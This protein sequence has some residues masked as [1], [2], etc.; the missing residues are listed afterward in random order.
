MSVDRL[1]KVKSLMEEA[2]LECLFVTPGP[3]QRYLTGLHYDYPG[4]AWDT[5]IT[6]DLITVEVVPLDGDPVVVAPRISAD[7]V[8]QTVDVDDV[9]S[10][11]SAENRTA[12]LKDLL[13]RQKGALGMEDHVPFKIFE[14][15]STAIPRLKMRNA[16]GL[17]S[18]ARSVKSSEE[19]EFM[20]QAAKIVEHGV[21]VGRE[22]IRES[23]TE[24]E[25]SLEVERAMRERGAESI[26][27]CVVQTGAKTASWD[28][29][30]DDRVKKGDMFLMDLSATYNGYHADV[31]RPT[32]VG[33][34][35]EK[36]KKVHAIILEAQ[37]RAIDTVQAGVKAGKV[38]EAASRVISESGYGDF[39]PFGI[40]HGLGLEAHEIPHLTEYRDMEM[41]LLPGM[42]MTLEPTIN[43][44]GEFGLRIEDDILVTDGGRE[45]LT[46]IGKELVQV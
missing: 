20:R 15:L 39:Y 18:R 19:L 30:T 6:W 14:Q 1:K 22:F 46:T 26:S 10:Y 5:I 21:K 9:R 41:A 28:S 32:V 34:P 35:S 42:V 8:R 25:I 23:V 17:L 11:S 31:T 2:G 36:Q 38:N 27:Y 45:S 33:E 24:K 4:D 40:G 37:Q 13:G 44:P 7:W 12:I 29:P 3:N 16:S 43:L